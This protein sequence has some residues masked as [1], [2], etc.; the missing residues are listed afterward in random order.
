MKC[1]LCHY[2][3]GFDEMAAYE[4]CLECFE[5]LPPLRRSNLVRHLAGARCNKPGH[6]GTC[7]RLY[8]EAAFDASVEYDWVLIN[9]GLQSP[10]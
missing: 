3:G 2:D 7:D 10:C 4:L 5:R 1:R 9:Q 8:A 6:C